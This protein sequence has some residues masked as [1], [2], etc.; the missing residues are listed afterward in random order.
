MKH[1]VYLIT[2][3]D[4]QMY[5]GTTNIDR[6]TIRM[7]QHKY[8]ERFQ[9]HQFIYKIIYETNDIFDCYKMEEHY[10]TE[11]NTY[12]NGL[13]GSVNGR[14]KNS[15]TTF[16]TLGYKFSS[17]SKAK[18]SATRKAK[19]QSGDIVT[20]NKGKPWSD[21]MKSHFSKIR[22]GVRHNSKLTKETVIEIRNKYES[23]ETIEGVG[24]IQ[25]N[26]LSLSYVWAF[27]KNMHQH[28]E[29]LLLI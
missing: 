16:T 14:G 5:V 4:G 24:E 29:Y 3:N 20:W 9:D 12:H 23:N 28:T 17:K 27:S 7:K 1:I 22:K 18:M 2:R 11:Y 6:V 21:E 25:G 15:C 26:G 19:M 8:S 13:N 10:I